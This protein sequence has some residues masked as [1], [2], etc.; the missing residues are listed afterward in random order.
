VIHKLI[1]VLFTIFLASCDLSSSGFEAEGY[2]IP[3]ISP[4]QVN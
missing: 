2:A 1:F 3:L 4:D